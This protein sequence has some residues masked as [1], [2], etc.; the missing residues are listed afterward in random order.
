M[1]G[2]RIYSWKRRDYRNKVGDDDDGGD[3]DAVTKAIVVKELLRIERADV[4]IKFFCII[5]YQLS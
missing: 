3:G 5:S 1:D 2:S 4:L